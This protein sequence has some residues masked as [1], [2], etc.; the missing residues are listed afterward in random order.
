MAPDDDEP[1][2]S[3]PSSA[4]ADPAGNK[5]RDDEVAAITRTIEPKSDSP[6]RKGIMGDGSG[7]DTQ[8]M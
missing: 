1:P 5:Q 7:A 6:S 2:I 8:K 3:P 4:E